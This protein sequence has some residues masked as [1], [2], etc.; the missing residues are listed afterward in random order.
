M[1]KLATDQEL[2][3][4]MAA[5]KVLLPFETSLHLPRYSDP[6]ILLCRNLRSGSN[7]LLVDIDLQAAT[8]IGPL[9]PE[10]FPIAFII[11]PCDPTSLDPN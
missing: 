10:H 4:R 2:P 5:A 1:F 7:L 11:G 6:K 9:R 8:S 3:R